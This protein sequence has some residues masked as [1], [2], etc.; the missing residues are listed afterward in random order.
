MRKMMAAILLLA[1]AACGQGADSSS[2]ARAEDAPVDVAAIEPQRFV[3]ETEAVVGRW[4]FDRTC[5]LYDLVFYADANVDY[6]DYSSEG[7]VVAYGGQWSEEPENQRVTLSLQQLDA[8][9]HVTGEAIDYV[10]DLITPPTDDLNGRFG[11]ADGA[12]G[13]DVH[14]K[15]CPEEDRE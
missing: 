14:A 5:G 3:L 4:S 8:E 2:A 1:L 15:R 10:L 6:F 9:G 12:F 7:Q 11:R 13:I